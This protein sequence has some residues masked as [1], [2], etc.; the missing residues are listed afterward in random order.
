MLPNCSG[1][2]SRPCVCMFIWNCWSLPIGRAPMRPTAACTFCALIA[3]TMSA[4]V[5]LQIVEALG[6]EPDAHRIVLLAEQ[7]GLADPGRARQHVD[8]VDDRVIR[9]EQRVLAAVLAVQHDELQDGR[10][11]LLHRQAL[12]LH[13]RRELRQGGLHPV[14]D[15]DRVDV[16][17]AAELEAD[18]Q[19]VAAVIAARRLHV[20][21]LVDADDLRLDR[22]RDA[23]FDDSGGGSGIG[24]GDLH[25]R[26][27]DVRELRDRNASHRQRAGDRDDDRDD[28]RQT[29]A[30]DEDRRR[31]CE[32]PTSSPRCRCSL[33]RACLALHLRARGRR[34]WRDRFARA[35]TLHAL[36][37]D[38][39][40]FA[41]A[42]A[43]I[44]AV[45]GVDWPC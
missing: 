23:G 22:L 37:D 32:L 31:S 13:L 39:L 24:G 45:E 2:V 9:D 30:I 17:I 33:R 18:G 6:V 11:F 7:E 27:H 8:N 38:Q 15:V 25:L 14:V 43:V 34:R 1:V 36:A 28:D 44:T 10:G 26:R 4:A 19:V 3:L 40:A 20:D 16:G 5:S 42:R 35:N 12:Q 21:H 29:R 41:S